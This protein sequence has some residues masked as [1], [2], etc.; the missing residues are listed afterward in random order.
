M[1]GSSVN[2]YFGTTPLKVWDHC[3]VDG[4]SLHGPRRHRICRARADERPRNHQAQIL[5]ESS[6][7]GPDHTLANFR[8]GRDHQYCAGEGATQPYTAVVDTH[9]FPKP[10]VGPAMDAQYLWEA[11]ERLGVRFVNYFGIGQ[12]LELEANCAYYLDCPGV[13]AEP[14]QKRLCKW[15]RKGG[16]RPCKFLSRYP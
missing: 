1:N 7:Q 15:S 16:L 14:S 13:A 9:V 3:C 5:P 12:V 6:S 11:F 2:Q 4:L 10:F 8:P